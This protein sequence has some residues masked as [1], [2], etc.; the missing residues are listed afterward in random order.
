MSSNKLKQE[1]NSTG[2]AYI[3]VDYTKP[4]IL[5]RLWNRLLGKKTKLKA[6][7]RMVSEAEAA[8][9]KLDYNKNKNKN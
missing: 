7:V 6:K 2:N 3:V 1:W 5:I 9:I 4:N 8:T